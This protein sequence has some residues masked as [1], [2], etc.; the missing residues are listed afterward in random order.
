MSEVSPTF[1]PTCHHLHCHV[2][3]ATCQINKDIRNAM[4][5]NHTK[6]ITYTTQVHGKIVFHKIGSWCQNCWGPLPKGDCS[7]LYL[8]VASSRTVSYEEKLGS[9]W[10]VTE[11]TGM[12]FSHVSLVQWLLNGVILS[13]FSTATKGIWWRVETFWWLELGGG[14]VSS[15]Q[16]PQMMLN[17]W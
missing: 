6:T 11:I 7:I 14:G 3:S 13:L 2:S 12:D 5:Q 17:M 1:T 15:E 16:R 10:A 8:P 4:R 9:R